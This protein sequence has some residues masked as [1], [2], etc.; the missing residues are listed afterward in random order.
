MSNA[1]IAIVSELR[2]AEA[3]RN[4]EVDIQEGLIAFVDPVLIEIVLS[5]L[6]GNAWKFTSKT[7]DAHIE[8]G[9][10][11][12]PSQKESVYYVKDNGAGFNPEYMGRMFMLFHRLHS[13]EEFEGTGIGLAIVERIVQRHGG[14][15]WAEGETGKGA[16][17]FFTLT[18]TSR[19]P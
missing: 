12:N 5:N 7:E 6:V 3:D 14:R 18:D 9:T 19:Q 13:D 11:K 15:I 16:T 17:I 2:A 10:L 8:F 4:V 1:A